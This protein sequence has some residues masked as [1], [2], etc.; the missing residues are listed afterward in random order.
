MGKD[1]I[2]RR[3]F[4]NGTRI[5][6]GASLIAP[7]AKLGAE[8]AALPADYY[9]PAKTGLRG[10]HNGSWEV[11]HARVRGQTWPVGAPEE[12]FDLI[13]VGGGI[14]GL[15]AARF[16]RQRKADA[17][18]LIL[19]NHDDFGGHAKRN[20]FAINGQTR[21]GYGGTES[22]DTPSAYSEP[23]RK[24]LIEIG[25]DTKKFYEAFD[26]TLYAKLGLAR[27]IVFDQENFGQQKLVTG[28]GKRSWEEFA[29][30]APFNEQARKDFIRVQTEQTDY[31][32]GLSREQRY[33]K[34]RRVSYEAFLREY[35]KVDP[36]LL[37][38][39]RKWGISFWC[40]G[41]DQIPCTLIHDYD[42]GMPG[43][44]HTL[45][46]YHAR[47][48]DPYIF[49]FPDGNASVAR[50]LVRSLIPS[51]MP[52]NTM[53]DVVTTRADYSQLD[54]HA[55]P[56]RIRLN[57][58]AVNVRHTADGKA[59]DVTYVNGGKAHTIRGSRCIMA[60][61]NMAIPYIIPDLPEAQKKGLAYGVKVPLTYTKVLVPNWRPFAE[62]GTD[63]VYYTK[64]FYKQ[65]ELDYP[66]SLGK[67]KRS[68]TPDEPM[69]LHMCYVHHDNVNKGPELWREGRR[70]LLSTP[71]SVFEHHVK[72]Q[73]N[74][75]LS[76][77]G[78][79]ADRDVKA[80]TVN[81]WSHGYAYEPNLIW[82]PDYATEAEK[83]WVIGRQPFG[84]IAIANSDSAAQADT[85][86]A[87]TQ[88][89]R[90]VEEVSEHVSE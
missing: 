2:T 36:Q 63:F 8:N 79:D 69:I 82:E 1:R 12:Q 42:G 44:D 6:I 3:D 80:I 11:M 45:P 34:L 13:V 30:L 32:P 22:I 65:V 85:N 66:V 89:F 68:Q 23:A 26:Q 17:R 84:R 67:Y 55:A 41:I 59:V 5:A 62:L 53:E 71:F 24:T 20:E 37:E 83:P 49:H 60:C 73:L 90:A 16:F 88:A 19:D 54:R 9:P 51:A 57:S 46:R 76:S 40:V 39:W 70:R 74:Q 52:G 33:E 86:A 43:L 77:A 15:S 50:L 64:D 14:S 28:Y 10:N 75:A 56:V 25:I 61:Y 72:D 21:I 4:L 58:T 48:D 78:F 38:F 29:K 27:A 47:G 18:I 87:I 81:R 7:W 31:L 35:C